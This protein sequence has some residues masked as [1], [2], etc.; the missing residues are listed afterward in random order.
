MNIGIFIGANS[1][2]ATVGGGYYYEKTIVKALNDADT[3]HKFYLFVPESE[4]SYEG[5]NVIKYPV[6]KQF[7]TVSITILDKIIRRLA[8]YS[9]VTD[10]LYHK[11]LTHKESSW[12]NRQKEIQISFFIDCIKKNKID[13]IYYPRAYAYVDLDI[14]SFLTFWDA[15]HLE[16]SHFPETACY[17]NFEKRENFIRSSLLK[18]SIIFTE[19][20]NG[21]RNLTKYYGI[22]ER[23]IVTVYQFPANVSSMNLSEILQKKILSKYDLKKEEFIFYPAQFWAHKNHYHIL[24]SLQYLKEKYNFFIK[25]VF[26][27]SNKGNM[28]Y[29]KKQAAELNVKEQIIF[30]G[31]VPSEDIYTFYKNTLSLVMPTFLGPTN[32]PIVEALYLGCPIICTDMEGH[33]EIAQ[34]A[35]LYVQPTDYVTM[36]EHIYSLY[37]NKSLRND[38]ISKLREVA[39][40]T[41][42]KLSEA[43]NILLN[44]F[45]EFEQIR[46]CWE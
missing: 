19:S 32:M 46:R 38:L 37:T 27:G 13:A 22:P 36:G 8:L 7:K 14:P 4:N 12:Y 26:S 28:D 40:T 33:R 17:G 1:Q 10:F 11:F 42:Y 31:F 21:K 45:D 24:K 44:T 18:A 29:I 25:A 39:L 5:S 34:E 2:D 35:A 15:G 43:V 6:A 41:K 16:H 23:K 20:I 3:H 30:V 9:N